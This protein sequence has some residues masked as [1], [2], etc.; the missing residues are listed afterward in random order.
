MLN[1]K[2]RAA[3]YGSYTDPPQEHYESE[4]MANSAAWRDVAPQEHDPVTI[5]LTRFAAS[6]ADLGNGSR[7][8]AEKGVAAK[9]LLPA[10]KALLEDPQQPSSVRAAAAGAVGGWCMRF[11]QIASLVS[12]DERLVKALGLAAAPADER[13]L[14]DDVDLATRAVAALRAVCDNSEDGVT[15][16]S[17]VECVVDEAA[18]LMTAYH[19]APAQCR[20]DAALLIAH[21]ASKKL[22]DEDTAL[23][24]A[25]SAACAAARLSRAPGEADAAA[26]AAAARAL[27]SLT[28][29]C[30]AAASVTPYAHILVPAAC[31][32]GD[33]MASCAALD[34]IRS[35]CVADEEARKAFLSAGAVASCT[36]RL[37]SSTEDAL[38]ASVCEV[39]AALCADE[40]GRDAAEKEDTI[41]LL[42]DAVRKRVGLGAHR[43][44]L[45]RAPGGPVD[46]AWSA[47]GG[48]LGAAASA[49]QASCTDHLTNQQRAAR[50][51]GIMALVGACAA[52]KIDGDTKFRCCAA[53]AAIVDGTTDHIRMLREARGAPVLAALGPNTD[54]EKLL[55]WHD[56]AFGKEPGRNR[57][58]RRGP[59]P[60]ADFLQPDKSV[61][62]DPPTIR[63]AAI[64]ANAFKPPPPPS[65]KDM[66]AAEARILRHNNRGFDRSQQKTALW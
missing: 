11:S 57:G 49:L 10:V 22:I 59:D 55:N 36:R 12:G 51:G 58:A 44:D 42:V 2:H 65:A 62:P 13:G 6:A 53:L 33:A 35:V 61:A 56:R 52:Q 9:R 17:A 19:R 7:G 39:L 48:P 16:V 31:D 40:A 18:R 15:A 27:R 29:D 60:D 3:I 1:P 14:P 37:V 25:K 24:A 38:D 20:R 50:L 63:A 23:R 41:R 43:D 4:H 64:A 5:L 46:A 45:L 30:G 66:S 26:A 47:P 8:D 54:A 21:M 28:E 32:G 34:A